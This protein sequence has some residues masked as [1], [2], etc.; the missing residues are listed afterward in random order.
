[1]S[2]SMRMLSLF[3]AVTVV[4]GAY[5]LIANL[6]FRTDA[7]IESILIFAAINI[8]VS[9]SFYLPFSAGLLSLAQAGFMGVGAYMSASIT[10]LW[11]F[12]FTVGPLDLTF[13]IALLAGGILAAIVGVLTAFPALRIRGVY[14]LL[15]TLAISE[16]IR[17]F[18]LNFEYTGGASGLGGIPPLTTIW[19][20][21]VA[22]VLVVLF[23]VRVTKSRMG[24]A[25]ESM[26]EDQ[27]AAEVMGVDL[28]RHKVVAFAIGAFLAGISGGLYAHYALYIDSTNF[29][30]FRSIEILIF[31]LLGGYEI[32]AGPIYG[33]FYLT[34]LPEWLRIIQDW[35][36]IIFGG[37]LIVMMILRPAGLISKE[38][39]SLRY[40]RSTL[41]N[42]WKPRVEA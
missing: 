7:Y 9:L 31:T 39:M 40:W 33:G 22:L 28:T 10:T 3:I 20:V 4:F 5:Y 36:I 29:G 17:V 15:M 18:F 11:K 37:L 19:N 42:L 14:L 30:V 1:M 2:T 41:A 32:Y 35:R 38:M 23:F 24:R 16:I 8:I 21:Y 34:F 27:D 6:F 26:K 12:H 13:F 25:F